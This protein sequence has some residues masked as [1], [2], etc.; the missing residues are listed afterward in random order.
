MKG[1]AALRVFIAVMMIVSVFAMA[2]CKEEMPPYES[3][4]QAIDTQQQAYGEYR[5]TAD[6]DMM[7]YDMKDMSRPDGKRC[8][9]YY[10]TSGDLKFR[11]V[12]LEYEVDGNLRVD[13]YNYMT[14]N[15]FY[16]ITSYL[17]AQTMMPVI[18]KYYV[19]Q[20]TMYRID[21]E[22]KTL[23]VADDAAAAEYY[24]SWDSLKKMYGPQ[25]R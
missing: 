15:A 24:S 18:T 12:T 25:E 7:S 21:E 23:T 17:D 5:K 19:W 16:I 4:V 2:G 8:N 11:N 3:I 1:T 22:A 9:S 10:V 20:G 13:E 14:D 6:P